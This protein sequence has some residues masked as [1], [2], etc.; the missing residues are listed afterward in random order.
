M[1]AS[2]AWL[3]SQ[4]PDENQSR[5]SESL[6]SYALGNF[7]ILGLGNGVLMC[8]D[9]MTTLSSDQ[10]LEKHLSTHIGKWGL[11]N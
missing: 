1:W 5:R 8:L 9:H 2:G 4:C 3:T 10:T 7:L 11:K 6:S